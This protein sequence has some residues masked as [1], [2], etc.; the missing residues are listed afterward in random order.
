MKNVIT[1][2]SITGLLE[3]GQTASTAGGSI[4][5]AVGLVL[6]KPLLIKEDFD[7]AGASV[8]G[9]QKLVAKRVPLADAFARTLDEA[10]TWCFRAKE[11]LKPYLG[12]AHSSLWRP[13]GFVT[14]LRVPIKY[15][16]LLALVGKLGDYLE[17]NP[18]Q[19]NDKPKVNV[20]VARAEELH[21][22]L[23]K[24]KGDLDEQDGLIN[25]AHVEQDKA[26]AALRV[27][28]QGLCGEL[29]QLIGTS[30]PRWHR[31]G[32][33]IPA[34]P[35]KPAQP[36][37]L[38]VSSDMPGKA[39]VS[40]ATVP[41]AKRYRFFLQKAGTTGEPVAVGTSSEPLFLIEKFDGGGRYHVFVSAVNR[42]GNE[43]PRSKA[44]V[45]D[46]QARAA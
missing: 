16:G 34:E 21:A 24:V 2:L 31:F 20:T 41:Y 18:E 23:M 1:T 44:V 39:L 35:E 22:A 36:D 43:G 42:A 27:R 33:N 19:S 13:T 29:K 26:L 12:D 6:N 10:R 38:E 17:D 37:G 11:T 40:C 9:Y 15:D 25:D 32:L 8:S 46:V 45:A 3:L 4:G 5:K 30:D 7:L 14:S 28:L